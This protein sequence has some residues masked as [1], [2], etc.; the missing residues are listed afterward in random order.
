M[1]SLLS[2]IAGLLALY[3][4][5]FPYKLAVNYIKARRTGLPIIIV[6]IDQNHFLWMVLSVPLR[7][8]FKV[9]NINR[10]SPASRQYST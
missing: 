10:P 5:R 6:P 7:P 3:L 1:L 4:A 9:S 2:I 8:V